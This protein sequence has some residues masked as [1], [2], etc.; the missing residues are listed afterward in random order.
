MDGLD[1]RADDGVLLHVEVAGAGADVLVLSGGPGYEHYLADEALAPRGVRSWFPDPRGVGRSGGGAHGLTQA[2]ADLEA[3]RRGTG[4]DRWTVLGHSWGGDLAVRYALDH[5]EAVA[6]V[7]SVAGTGVQR[8][9]TW[10]AAYRAGRADE[11]PV[12][13][14]YE[15]EVHRV[16]S[17]S[18][19]AWIHR[20]DLLRRLAG[21]P[22]PMTFVAAAADVRPSWPLEQLAALVPDG[23]FLRV[24]GVPHNFWLTHPGIWVEVVSDLVR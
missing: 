14:P 12:P 4:A 24:P 20:P 15:P 13:V 17:E 19:L 1:V 3:I 10:K 18:Y 6:R 5:P 23:R 7:V 16:L 21:C 9:E 8:D 22:V 2:V 11:V